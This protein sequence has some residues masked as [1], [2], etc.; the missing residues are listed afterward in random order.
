MRR[1]VRAGL[2][3]ASVVA[4]AVVVGPSVG[5][6]QSA[7]GLPA[8]ESVFGFTPCA[9][10]KLANYEQISTYFHKLDQ[11]SDR[12]KLINIG[13]TSEGR[14]QLMAVVS[15]PE[16]LTQNNLDRYRNISERLAHAR[17]LSESEAKQLS[18]DGKTIAWVDFGIHSTEVAPSQ[19]APQF[20]YDLVRSESP[21]AKSIR[22]D[23]ITLF[24][25]NVNPDGTSEI[26]D[27]YMQHVGGPY[28]DSSYP[29]LYQKYA[30]HD[31]NRD[32][33]MFNLAET[34]NQGA[35]LWAPVVP[36]A[37]LRHAP[38][39]GLPGAHLHPA[40]QGSRQPADPARGD[41]RHQPARRLADPAP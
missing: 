13:K 15:S 36:A 34:R 17:G 41:P 1:R 27:W 28:Q 7:A 9:D 3:I 31:D 8:P 16:N 26:S 37:A 32:W 29:E 30:G 40:V 25:P 35:L 21:E 14:D 24:D 5:R 38:D 11:A 23:V 19:T 18:A 39:R 33:F 22:D 4:L 20:A 10:Y 6:T 2:T 12:M